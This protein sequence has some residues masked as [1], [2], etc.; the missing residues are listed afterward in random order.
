MTLN[1]PANHCGA[2]QEDRDETHTN[3][4]VPVVINRD[5]GECQDEQREDGEAGDRRPPPDRSPCSHAATL[6]SSGGRFWRWQLLG[7]NDSVERRGGALSQN[8]ADLYTSST[9]SFDHRSFT[10]PI[11]RTDC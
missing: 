8:E 7:P 4:E 5:A 9:L 2:Q 1:L 3:L 11:A 6:K 10:P